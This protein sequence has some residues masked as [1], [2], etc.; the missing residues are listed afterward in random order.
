M[1]RGRTTR[2]SDSV[3]RLMRI[4][5]LVPLPLLCIA[6]LAVQLGSPSATILS[7][8][9]LKDARAAAD[10]ARTT[11]STNFPATEDPI[12]ESG[13]WINGGSAGLD[14]T[15]VRTIPNR[16]FGTQS[17]ISS[18]PYDDSTALLTGSWGNEQSAQ[19]TVYVTS[20]PG[21]CCVEV[22]LRLRRTLPS[23]KCTGDES[24]C[25]ILR[26]NAPMKIVRWMC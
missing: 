14:W 18:I 4:R 6:L 12:S 16:A 22:E 7:A 10:P 25:R 21:H 2:P 11:Y 5:R 23:H 26:P 3:K 17:G 15:N 9:F 13:N 20:A 8:L 19:A 24:T 1:L